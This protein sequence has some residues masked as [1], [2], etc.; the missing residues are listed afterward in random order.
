[1][2]FNHSR[3]ISTLLIP[4]CALAFNAARAANAP[5]LAA[6]PHSIAANYYPAA[7]KSPSAVLIAAPRKASLT[8]A[9][10]PAA[11][12]QRVPLDL[13]V[14]EL[15]RIMSRSQLLYELRDNTEEEESVEVV[16][17]PALVPMSLDTQIPLGVVGSLQWSVDHPTQVWRILL[18]NPTP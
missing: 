15:P 8:M 17:A 18:P 1:M 7:F 14:P 2:S 3:A 6:V 16:A 10:A 13:R 9:A 4:V 12:P 5:D 11:T